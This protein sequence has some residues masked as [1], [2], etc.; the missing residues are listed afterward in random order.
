MADVHILTHEFRPKRGGAGV[1]CERI[2]ETLSQLGKEVTVWAPGYVAEAENF[3][4]DYDVRV[5][6]RLKG[7]RNLPCLLVTARE[8]AAS[9]KTLRTADVY[10][11]EPG[12]IAVFMLLTLF[13]PK[14]WKRLVITLHGSEILRYRRSWW[15]SAPLFRRLA[16]KADCIH[17]LSSHNEAVLLD[18]L[19]E[20]KSKLVR[21]YGMYLPNE[22]PPVIEKGQSAAG[23]GVKL[24]C[25][26]RIHPRKGQLEL[27]QAVCHLDPEIQK[28]LTVV[29]VGQF[30]KDRY[31]K[32]LLSQVQHTIAK[33]EFTGGISDELLDSTY[34]LADIFALTSVPYGTSVE[35]LGLVYM[36]AA[37]YGLPV[38][39]HRIGGVSDFVVHGVN[40][41]LCEPDDL[42]ALSKNLDILIRN[43]LLRK[44]LGEEGR[45]RVTGLKWETVVKQLFPEC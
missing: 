24:L 36:E 15:W 37:Q 27:L 41:Y 7:T 39:A 19:P 21:G 26:A 45:K 30:V 38:I 11:G 42:L 8:V 33:V 4:P 16:R 35:G 31:Y 28:Q 32:D 13:F 12:P 40:G 44:Q 10:L 43:P 25:V 23:G 6:R 5:L 2:A 34:A 14:F 17:V 18:W 29:F 1:V 20:L 3:A 9:R 22:K